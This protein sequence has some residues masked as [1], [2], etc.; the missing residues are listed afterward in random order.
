MTAQKTRAA[1]S[2]ATPEPTV[3]SSY[4]PVNGLEMY[5]EIHGDGDPLFLLHGGLGSTE[6]FSGIMPALSSGRQVIAVDL[7]AHGRTTDIGRPMTYE[8]MAGDIA[9]L[10]TYLEIKKV[11]IL[12]FSLGAGVALRA[13]IQHPELVKKLVVVSIP[14][15]RYGWY[16]EV[17]AAM[18]KVGASMAE[19]L[20]QS[21]IYK[22]YERIAPNPGDWPVLL[23]KLGDLVRKDYDW[24]KEVAHIKTPTLLVFG[25]ADAI[26]PSHMVEFF[27]LLGGGKKD[28]GWDGSGMP[29]SRLAILPGVTHYKICSSPVLASVV[30]AFLDA[31]LPAA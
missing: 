3:K 2:R 12:G 9:T 16:P 30:T 27:G 23:E 24:S 15:R 13:A 26:L 10:A 17:V 7:Q 18:A 20:K 1:K 4:A 31:P 14:F 6:M 8:A 22:V 21:P 5:Y 25:D 29:D 11:D 28:P 19:D